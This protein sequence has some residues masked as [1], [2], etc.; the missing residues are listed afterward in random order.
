MSTRDEK[1]WGEKAKKV[2]GKRNNFRPN[3]SGD[4]LLQKQNQN[5]SSCQGIWLQ[6]GSKTGVS[7]GGTK[8]RGYVGWRLFFTISGR[9]DA[10]KKK[11]D[12]EGK[13]R[14]KKTAQ[15]GEGRSTWVQLGDWKEL[16]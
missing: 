13:D 16:H 3:S 1:T 7:E 12:T 9:E 2:H 10:W 15:P 5:K 6:E 11:D 8:A 4:D 14:G